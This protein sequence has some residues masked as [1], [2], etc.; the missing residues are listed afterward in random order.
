MALVEAILGHASGQILPAENVLSEEA[1]GG[2]TDAH[3]RAGQCS[4]S[5]QEARKG[6]CFQLGPDDKDDVQDH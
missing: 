6:N 3:S 1:R 2:G 4:A 5:V